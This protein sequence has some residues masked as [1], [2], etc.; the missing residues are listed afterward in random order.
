VARGVEWES[1]TPP[2]KLGFLGSFWLSFPAGSSAVAGLSLL[3]FFLCLFLY[4]SLFF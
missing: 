2:S 3:V 1:L 4:S